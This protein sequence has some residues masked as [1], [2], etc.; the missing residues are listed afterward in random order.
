M[1]LLSSIKK[2]ILLTK[3]ANPADIED[4][5]ILRIIFGFS[6]PG[7]YDGSAIVFRHFMVSGVQF[8]GIPG[9][10]LMVNRS[11]TIIRFILYTE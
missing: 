4:N 10:F 8:F 1:D 11:A 3:A 9:A 2:C 6:Y 7:R 5:M